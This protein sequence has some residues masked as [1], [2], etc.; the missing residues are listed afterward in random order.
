MTPRVVKCW[1]AGCQ[2]RVINNKPEEAR[3]GRCDYKNTHEKKENLYLASS[4]SHGHC[5]SYQLPASWPQ[6][7]PS[8]YAL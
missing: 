4:A 6:M 5:V 8:R 2:W 1:T 3:D 7:H